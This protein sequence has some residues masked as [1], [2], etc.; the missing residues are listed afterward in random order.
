MGE[1]I[2]LL[3]NGINHEE[4]IDDEEKL[5]LDYLRDDLHLTGTKRGCDEKACG[6][7]TVLIDGKAT[8]SCKTLLKD[9]DGKSVVTIEGLSKDGKLDPVQQAF[10]DHSAV[11]CGFCTPGLIMAVHGLLND[12][13]DPTEEEIKKAL[14][15][16]L[17]RCGTY[18]RLVAAVHQAAAVIRNQSYEKAVPFTLK[19]TEK[20]YVGKSFV[21]V[22]YA[23]KVTGG[24]KFFADYYFDD[25][26]YG[27]CVYSEYPFAEILD[28]D[29]SEAE[30]SEGF[31]TYITYK[32][33]PGRNRHGAQR[34]Q[35]VLV[36]K[37]AKHRGDVLAVVYAKTKKQAEKA[38]SLVKVTAREI[39]GVFT[40]E[41][42]LDPNSP[43]IPDPECPKSALPGVYIAGEKHNLCRESHLH[44]GDVEKAFKECDA[45][46]EAT[47]E[48]PREEHA[49]IEVDGAVSR[50]DEDGRICVYAPNQDPF[51][52]HDQLVNVLGLDFDKIRVVHTP[53]GGAFGGKLELTTHAFCAIGTMKT[54]LPVKM[55]LNRKDSMR[56]HSKRHGYKMR[57]KIGVNNDGKIMAV[58]CNNYCDGGP[59][60][61]WS[62]RTNE[63]NLNWGCGPY[64]VPNLDMN[65]YVMYTNN[66]V[67]GAMR[68]F[69]S[70][71]SHFAMESIL[72]MAA[73]KIGMDKLK[74]REINAVDYNSFNTVGQKILKDQ[75]GIALKPALKM[76]RKSLEEKM[77]PYKEN[78]KEGEHIG[79]GFGC[80]WRSIGGGFGNAD[81]TGAS[82]ELLPDGKVLYKIS[83]VE[84]GQ[85]SHTS[86]MQI[87]SESSGVAMEDY[88]LIAGDTANVPR[89]GHVS[90]SRGVFLWG[91]PTMQAGKE[92]KDTVLEKAK[93]FLGV[94]KRDIDLDES[95]IISQKTGE[96]LMTLKEFAEKLD[97]PLK[98][99]NFFDMPYTAPIRSNTNEDK[100]LSDEDYRVFYTA[101]YTTA[102]AV[103]KVN[104]KT[105]NVEVLHI[106]CISDAG[107]IINPEAAATQIEGCIVMGTGYALTNN[108]KVENGVV[109]TDTLGK[110]KV[111][112]IT[113]CVP[114]MDIQ[115]AEEED[116]CSPYGAKG[117]AEIGILAIAPAI[118]NAIAD[119]TN[120]RIF[121]LPVCDH[122]AELKEALEK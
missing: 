45:V 116:A 4:V 89:G 11:Q 81:K 49:W 15:L 60:V 72:D 2:K 85:G 53:C 5:L 6:A 61:S 23:G 12:N 44:R 70:P 108:F 9:M 47:F 50:Y 119:A 32:D 17:C 76:L 73:D 98:V 59:Y 54:G 39:P 90:A 95:N 82:L 122:K 24:T 58:Q 104:E 103:V 79:I 56:M 13:P 51:G 100:E 33:V 111:P 110:C 19:D 109:K 65:A 40:I 77:L 121:N 68:G 37:Y 21:R 3:V 18:P 78:A 28:L 67:C 94:E 30:K 92:F 87:A 114:S 80:G 25:M 66:P 120:V 101:S 97:E 74:I 27:Q 112:R 102:G 115:F 7:C 117:I 96:T 31:V 105:G 14:R 75:Q 99:V 16:H 107:K 36:E 38:A 20:E 106:S 42:A 55:V 64:N 84:M 29:F 41:D 10:I 113:D 63:Q 8:R 118:T 22:D 46:V 93:D 52:D 43:L 86:L 69:G 88:K 62:H 1:T 26:I 91:H 48:V 34:D 83:C 35:Q 57:Y 71:Q